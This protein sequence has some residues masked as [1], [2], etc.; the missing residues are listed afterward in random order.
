MLNACLKTM[1]CLKRPQIPLSS[2]TSNKRKYLSRW[3]MQRNFTQQAAVFPFWS[4]N[5]LFEKGEILLLQKVCRYVF[6]N[7]GLIFLYTEIFMSPL[8]K[9]G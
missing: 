4:L 6:T 5:P 7:L 3:G 1:P 2:C 9:R 8:V